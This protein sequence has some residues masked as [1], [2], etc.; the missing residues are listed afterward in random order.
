MTKGRLVLIDMN[1]RQK[2]MN[3]YQFPRTDPFT[4]PFK[5]AGT[6]PL[7]YQWQFDGG[8]I[9]NATSSALAL[10]NVVTNQSGTYSG[11]VANIAGTNTS[12]PAQ[13]TVYATEIGRAHV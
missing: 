1:V 12:N 11:V 2:T 8:K 7:S 6:S 5:A 13:L 3:E 9:T 4:D 10:T